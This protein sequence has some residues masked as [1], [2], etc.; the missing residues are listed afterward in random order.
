MALVTSE[1]ASSSSSSSS[2]SFTH[3]WKYDVFLSFRGEDTRLGFTGHLYNALRQQ[4]IHTFIDDNLPRGEKIS[5]ELLKT[6]EDST[7][8]IIIFSENY[9]SSAWCLDELAKIVECKKNDHLVVPVFYK[10]DPS[11][12]RNQKGKFGEELAKHEEKFKGDKKVQRWRE[13]LHEAASISGWHY[14][15]SGCCTEFEF[16][17]R[18]VEEISSNSK[19]NR[20]PLFVAEYL[21][22]INSRVE[23]I[24]LLLD[25]ESNDVR[26]VGIYG[27]GGVGK[28][29]IA[30]AIYNEIF[31]HFEG[32]SFLENV[33]ENSKTDKDIVELQEN[34]L[35]QILGNRNSLVC[36]IS[37]GTKKINEILSQKKVLIILDDVDESAQIV[38]LL[39]KHKCFVSGSRIII[40]TRDKRLLTTLGI[41]LSTYE[42]KELNEHEA[43][44]LFSRHAFRRYKPNEDYL[45]LA[46]KF[47]CY[48]KGLPLALVVMGADLYKRTKA[49]WKSRLDKYEKI[50]HGNIQE[51][52]KISYEGLDETEQNIFLD[53][54]CFFKGHHMNNVVDILKAC[55]FYPECGIPRLIEKC[56]VTLSQNN[57]LKMHDLVQQMGREIVRQESPRNLGE[58][59]RLWYY[60]DVLEVLTENKGSDKIQGI[61]LCSPGEPTKVQFND[62]F[63]KMKNLRLLIICNIKSCGCLEYLPNG[64]KLLYWQGFPWSSLPPKFYPK[65]LVSLNLSHSR[66]EKPVKQ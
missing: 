22:G 29:T 11:E 33:R 31:Y 48:A 4:G 25:I 21:V 16:I 35:C 1:G 8:S 5:D 13:A 36:N 57:E 6:I 32:R 3:Q 61:M 51:I 26:M 40:T 50:P 53:I 46:Y 7:I 27:L 56:L 12:V 28:T 63:L 43:I 38:N 15:N 52:L 49:E 44:E 2:F 10:V 42:V 66:I 14:N 39:G 62:Q 24:K 9:A 65:K 55:D 47:I 30:K 58:R 18:I 19:L 54:A 20:M 60:E 41:G 34:L 23:A 45:E 64:L 59:S 17:Q 37:G